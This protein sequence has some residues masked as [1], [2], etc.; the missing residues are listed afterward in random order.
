LKYRYKKAR[1]WAVSS[2]ADARNERDEAI[3][4]GLEVSAIA[5]STSGRAR[6]VGPATVRNLSTVFADNGNLGCDGCDPFDYYVYDLAE[7]VQANRLP[8]GKGAQLLTHVIEHVRVTGN[9]DLLLSEVVDYARQQGIVVPAGDQLTLSVA[10]EDAAARARH[11]QT[12]RNFYE[13]RFGQH[14]Q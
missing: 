1:E 2:L 9:R 14:P 4:A 11:K 8:I 3:A 13:A 5:T 6:V 10:A 7:G 12:I